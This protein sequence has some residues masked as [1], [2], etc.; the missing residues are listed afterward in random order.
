MGVRG[1]TRRTNTP[2]QKHTNAIKEI[3]SSHPKVVK[4]RYLPS[5]ATTI[6]NVWRKWERSV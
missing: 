3:L 6:G 1:L 4:I 2:S 5:T